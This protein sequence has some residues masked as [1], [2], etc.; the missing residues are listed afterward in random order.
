M[1]VA[2]LSHHCAPLRRAWLHPF[3]IFPLDSCR[4][5]QGILSSPS[6]SCAL[7]G[8]SLDSLQYVSALLVLE[9]PKLDIVLQMWS[10]KYWAQGIITFLGYT[11]TGK[12]QGAAGRLYHK[13]ILLTDVHLSVNQ[14]IQSL[15]AKPL[16]VGLTSRLCCWMVL[17]HLRCST[18]QVG[19][20]LWVSYQSIS[21]ACFCPK[22]QPSPPVCQ[23]SF[24]SLFFCLTICWLCSLSHCQG[25]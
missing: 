1:A 3:S 4:Q 5:K 25:H 6:V 10:H 11:L 12:V 17:F 20:T 14:H 9:R 23:L 21:P 2:F 15:S 16:C 8:L 7:G 18:L 24:P 13:D 19:W 22:Q